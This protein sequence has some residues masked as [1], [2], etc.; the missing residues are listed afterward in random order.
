MDRSWTEV[1]PERNRRNDEWGL[2]SHYRF[3][4]VFDADAETQFVSCPP[5]PRRRSDFAFSASS[6]KPPSSCDLVAHA[7]EEDQRPNC[8]Y[9]S[10]GEPKRLRSLAAPL[11]PPQPL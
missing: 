1:N 10:S 2:P 7:N 8:A 11:F 6:R 4:V 5:T 3:P 9:S